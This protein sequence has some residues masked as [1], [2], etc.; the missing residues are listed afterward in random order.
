MKISVFGLGYVGTVVTACLARDGHRMIGV[1][2]DP[3]KVDLVNSG[4]SP[5]I[6]AGVDALI[7]AGRQA[8]T[9]EATT[10]AG[11][12]VRE[13]EVSMICVGTPSRNTGDLDLTYVRRVCED[14]GS[15][16]AHKTGYHLVVARSTMLPGSVEGTIIPALEQTSGKK[17]GVDFGVAINPE[18]LREG[19]AVHDFDHPPKTV[20]G[21]GSERDSA[22]VA[23]LY[24]RIE[25]PLIRTSLQTAE[26]VKYADNIFHALKVTFANEIGALCKDLGVDGREVM[27]IFCQDRKLNLS[28][29]YL[30]PGFAY[31]GSCLP[32]DLR[33]LNRL[34]QS[35]AVELPMLRAIPASNEQ[36][37]RVAAERILATGKRRIGVLGFAFKGGTDDLRESPVV[38]LIEVLLGKGC[39]LKLFDGC[40]SLAR[41]VGANRR[42]I[43]ERIP[44]IS[45]L[46]VGSM[47]ELTEH[48][49]VIIVGNQSPEFMEALKGLAAS[50]SVFDLTPATIPPQTAAA[51]ERISS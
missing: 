20:I 26:M 11:R 47:A 13:S 28:P 25:A 16:L 37:I 48:A 24:E 22:I 33:A 42:Y 4:R 34:A 29:A 35:R 39:D 32:K 23:S 3:G 14:I 18:F 9:I 43:E 15:I 44:H 38:T 8:G 21:A 51:Y 27:E 5:I 30:R 50:Q 2:T 1:D 36:Q 49:E 31:G 6:E 46:M 45:R 17:A 10:D 41:L 12:A 19:T 40:V 7:A